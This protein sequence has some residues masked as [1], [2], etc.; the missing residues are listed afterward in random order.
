MSFDTFRGHALRYVNAVLAAPLQ[1]FVFV[2]GIWF[3]LNGI[4]AFGIYP[5]MAFGGGHMRSCTIQFLG[6][7]P[8]TVNGWHALFHLVTGVAALVAATIRGRALA[9]TWICGPFY[10]LIAALGF[11]G[12]DNVLHVMAV[13]T[14]GNIVHTTE[15]TILLATAAGST[16]VTRR[17]QLTSK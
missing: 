17:A 5:D 1:F 15:A 3:T 6:F 12:G 10:L 16:L 8:V 9:Y 2:V 14:F 7:I 11:V 13:D 4:I